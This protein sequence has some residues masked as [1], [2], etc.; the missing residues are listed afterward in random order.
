MKNKAKWIV[1]AVLLA[2]L[3]I[4]AGVLYPKLSGKVTL[5]DAG[6]PS[7]AAASDTAASDTAQ[8]QD[9]AADFTVYDAGGKEVKLSDFRGKPVIINFWASWCPP[10]KA[11]LPYFDEA[12]QQYGEDIVFL[13]VDLADG[14]SETQ[15]GAARYVEECGYAFPVYFDL[16]GS[17]SNA[18][19]LYS[20]PQTV[21]VNAAGEQ[22]FSR[23]GGLPEQ[24]VLDLAAQLAAD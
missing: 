13:M 24:T 17:A 6:D 23:I 11:E 18:Y 5:P 1:L 15:E 22:V 2:A 4:T 21:G 12:F 16:S 14:E 3:L 8:P 20:I 7:G 9:L 10:C 19:H